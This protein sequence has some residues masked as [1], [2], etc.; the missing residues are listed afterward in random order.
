MDVRGKGQLRRRDAMV[1][2][3]FEIRMKFAIISADEDVRTVLI[4]CSLLLS[5]CPRRRRRPT[6]AAAA[7]LSTST[8]HA[9]LVRRQLGTLIP[10]KVATPKSLVRRR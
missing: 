1:D 6:T 5:R 3:A 9:S 8:M 7:L 4:A 2:R 10:P